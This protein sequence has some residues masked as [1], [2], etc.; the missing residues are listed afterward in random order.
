MAAARKKTT[1]KNQESPH[2]NWAVA[3]A[4]LLGALA[5]LTAYVAIFAPAEGMLSSM[6][7]S[8]KGLG[9][10]L[11]VLFPPTLAWLC[12]LAARGAAGKPISP[13]RVL[14]NVALLLCLYTAVE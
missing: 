12:V 9:G 5:L 8:M 14:A 7:A 2:R 4:I 3:A 10:H 6:R 11:F 1:Q 13:W